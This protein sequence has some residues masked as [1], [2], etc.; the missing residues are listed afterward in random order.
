MARSIVGRMLLMEHKTVEKRI[1]TDSYAF[2]EQ[3][4]SNLEASFLKLHSA[5]LDPDNIAPTGIMTPEDLVERA[6]QDNSLLLR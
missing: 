4:K 6:E 2:S 1:A 3:D 5:L